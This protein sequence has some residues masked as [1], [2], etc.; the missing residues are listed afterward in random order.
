MF[1]W[2]IFSIGAEVQTSRVPAKALVSQVDHILIGSQQA[3]E[4]FQLFSQKLQLPIVWP[5]GSY[6]TF[7]S[8]GVGFGNVNIELIRR[9]PSQ[10]RPRSGIVGVALDPNSLTEALAEL[11]AHQV[12]HTAPAPFYA[13][14]Q[15]GAQHLYWTTVQLPT[16]PQPGTTFLVK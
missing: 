4:L 8:G 14:D 7:S 3:E 10:S 9:E 1:A 5:F 6:G 12:E 2:A 16:V 11:D 15:E 13:K